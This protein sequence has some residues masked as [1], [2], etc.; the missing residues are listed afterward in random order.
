MVLLMKNKVT[1]FIKRSIGINHQQMF[2]YHR[3]LLNPFR[4]KPSFLIIGSQKAGTTSMHY[5]LNQNSYIESPVI[6]ETHFFNMHYDRKMHYYRSI[7][8]LKK[9]NIQ[10]FESTPD[11]L[12]HPLAPELCYKHLPDVKI[13]VLLREPVSRAFSHFNFIKRRREEENK[14][15]FEEA[16]EREEE[17]VQKAFDIM[18]KDRYHSGRIFSDYAYKR[19]GEYAKHLKN[20]LKFY[21]KHHFYF[22]NFKDFIINP[23][24]ILE[25]VCNF[26]DIPYEHIT[27]V[28]HQNKTIYNN[29]I[30]DDT[31][32]ML[33]NYYLLHNEELFKLIGQKYD[34]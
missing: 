22:I 34:W 14:L 1:D 4:T 7:F 2:A 24:N 29:P 28:R 11:Y 20:W 9:K 21:P 8:P 19:K 3:Y 23:A 15:T 5:Y 6:K 31:K 27:T 30:K 32:Q 17:R 18:P 25:G 16:L 10:T 13:I 26:L 12:D 33:S